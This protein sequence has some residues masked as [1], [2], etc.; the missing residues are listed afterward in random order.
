ME[1]VG[2]AVVEV[3]AVVDMVVEV[4]E[5]DMRGTAVEE[6]VEGIGGKALAP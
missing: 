4:V 6:V 2:V 3:A 5:E 1:V